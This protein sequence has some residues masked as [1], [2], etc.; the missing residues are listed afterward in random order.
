MRG[1]TDPMTSKRPEI[2]SSC[3]PELH[4]ITTDCPVINPENRTSFADRQPPRLSI[5]VVEMNVT[6]DEMLF[7]SREKNH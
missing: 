5:L 2:P 3:P 4:S 6:S 1:I 7:L